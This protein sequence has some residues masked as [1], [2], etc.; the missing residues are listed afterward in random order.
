MS[1]RFKGRSGTFE[2]R[3]WFEPEAADNTASLVREPFSLGRDLPATLSFVR[4]LA[5]EPFALAAMRA[6][7]ARESPEAARWDDADVIRAIATGLVTGKLLSFRI[8][9]SALPVFDL[10][11][12]EPAQGQMEGKR[13]TE[14][15]WIEIE[16]LDTTGEPVPNEPYWI[17]LP[18]GEV[19]EGRLNELGRAYFDH[20]DPGN[21]TVRFPNLDDEAMTSPKPKLPPAAEPPPLKTWIEILLV[22]EE[23]RPMP[24]EAY[25]VTLPNGEV[26]EGSLDAAGKARFEE[27]DAGSCRVTFP[28][29]EDEAVAQLP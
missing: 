28:G 12:D 21:C 24:Y 4:A 19:R 1:A 10:L 13:V 22:T 3:Y 17:E 9:P 2:L 29:F 20:L 23:G 6:L 5:A 26:R 16:L 18:D 7:A 14:K 15:T 8:P 25:R 27:I 11:E